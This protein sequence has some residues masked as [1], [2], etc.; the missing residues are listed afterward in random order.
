MA[1]SLGSLVNGKILMTVCVFLAIALVTPLVVQA[2]GGG[3]LGT[4]VGLTVAAILGLVA[5]YALVA[6]KMPSAKVLVTL[7]ILIAIGLI[8]VQLLMSNQTTASLIVAFLGVSFGLWAYTQL[9]RRI[10]ISGHIT[11]PSSS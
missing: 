5:Y 10:W 4:F 8:I 9:R 7:G 1:R 6:G 3:L 2:V 11:Y